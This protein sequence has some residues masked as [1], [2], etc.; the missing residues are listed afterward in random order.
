MA[1]Q[2]FLPADSWLAIDFCLNYRRIFHGKTPDT[3]K[4]SEIGK[5]FLECAGKA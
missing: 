5:I 2:R 1:S 3:V 4:P